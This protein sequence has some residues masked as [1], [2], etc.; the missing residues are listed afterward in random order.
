DH[1]RTGVSLL[2]RQ[3]AGRAT[4]LVDSFGRFPP[5]LAAELARAPESQA[6]I[7]P[8][9]DLVHI[10]GPLGEQ[11]KRVLPKLARTYLV[12]SARAAEALARENPQFFFLAT[13]GT[14]YHGRLVSGGARNG[15]GY[16]SMQRE[17]ERATEA[18]HRIEPRALWTESQLQQLEER[19]RRLDE[20]L[21]AARVALFAQEKS[22]LQL[23]QQLEAHKAERARCQTEEAR[24][25]EELAHWQARRQAATQRLEELNSERRLLEQESVE[26]EAKLKQSPESL[27]QLRQQVEEAATRRTELS[28]RQAGLEERLTAARGEQ[29]RRQEAV[30]RLA[31]EQ[32]E[33]D[34]QEKSLRAEQQR[35]AQEEAEGLTTLERRKRERVEQEERCR[36]F[37][38]EL[39]ELRQSL[40]AREGMLRQQR[41]TLDAIREQRHA[42]EVE[43]A[44]LTS[45][46]QHAAQAAQGEFGLTAAELCHQVAERLAD[47]ALAQAE[48]RYLELKHKL[49]TMGPVNMMALEELTE[50]E[51][52]YGFL[53]KQRQDLLASIADTRDAIRE[54]DQVSGQQFAEAFAA[55]NRNFAETFQTLFGGGQATLR[56]T[57][58]D[59]PADCGIELICQPPGKRLQNVLLLSGGEKALA[60]LALLIAVFRYQPSPFCILDEVDAP[61]DDSNVGRFTNLVETMAPN[62]QFILITHNK[63]TMEVAQI[64]YGV[65]MQAAVTQL[66]SVRFDEQLRPTAA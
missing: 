12:N 1:A 62:T 61:L 21:R 64:L 28:A 33:R 44:R 48:T 8:V 14:C 53:S 22:L 38:T 41:T 27:Q 55:I 37:D 19:R 45:D 24:N 36:G 43:R 47:E 52:R 58:A 6:I 50:A 46:R 34:Q 65:T 9:A 2:R 56:L 18:R 51:E 59:N 60:A 10:N 23:E 13:D 32:L 3:E 35:L 57:D 54:I 5:K 17:L 63:K 26:I 39:G 49:E 15:N 40:A 11:A 25:Q 29:A 42:L 20:E 31:H 4:F 16:H 7:A 66:V 30:A